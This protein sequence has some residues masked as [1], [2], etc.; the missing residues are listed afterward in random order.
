[1]SLELDDVVVDEHY[2]LTPDGRI[3][4][5]SKYAAEDE[6]FRALIN[7]EVLKLEVERGESPHIGYMRKLR[8]AEPELF[9][10]T[11][12]LTYLPRGALIVDLLSEYALQVVRSLGGV[13]VKTSTMYNLSLPAISEHANLFGQRM[14]KAGSLKKELLLRYAACFGQ[15]ALLSRKYLT[16][17]DLPLKIFELADSYRYEQSGEVS[18]LARTRRFFMPDLHVLAKNMEEAK[19]EFLEIFKLI[20]SEGAKFGWTYY[21][22]YNVTEDFLKEHFSYI[23]ELVKYENK[24]VLLH[25]VESGKFYWKINIEFHYIDSQN[26]PLETAT[27]QIDVENAKRFGIRY[28]D[29]RGEVRFPIII[30]TAIHGSIE[31]FLFEFLEEAAKMEKR[32]RKA[33]LPTWLSPIQVRI[34]PVSK[35]FMQHCE[36]ILKRLK[37]ANI[38]ADVDDRDMSVSKKVLFAEKEWIPYIVV[39]GRSEVEKGV[40]RVRIRSSGKEVEMDLKELIDRISNEVKGF[41]FR[42]NYI[43]DRVSERPIWM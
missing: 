39:I 18:G 24:P 36:D 35:Q 38:R 3:Y 13:P 29:E 23:V 6:G 2:V 22:L 14:Y 1:M 25:V 41:P 19:A 9:S 15:F 40:L 5:A 4:H 20:L 12:H 32:G 42:E 28:V 11:G 17:K 10:D 30:H 33:M 26:R 21:S 37:A 34:I 31:R 16:F 8:I 43:G 27:V 7:K